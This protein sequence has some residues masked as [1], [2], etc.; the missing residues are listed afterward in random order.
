M[1]QSYSERQFLNR[2]VER[3]IYVLEVEKSNSV[4]AIFEENNNLIFHQKCMSHFGCTNIIF[5][6]SIM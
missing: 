5:A 6:Y 4:I 1:K 3:A 2:K